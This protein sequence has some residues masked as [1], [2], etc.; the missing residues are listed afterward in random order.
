MDEH[1]HICGADTFIMDCKIIY[2]IIHAFMDGTL[3][4]LPVQAM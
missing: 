2:F 3:E 1:K 4:S